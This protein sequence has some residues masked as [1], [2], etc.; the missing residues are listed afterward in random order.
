LTTLSN[1][2]TYPASIIQEQFWLINRLQPDNTAYNIPSL[3]RLKGSLNSDFIKQSVS[4]IT[5]RH[6][7][8]R[9]TF[10]SENGQLQ[11]IITDE[12]RCAFS[13]ILLTDLTSEQTEEKLQSLIRREV[14]TP[15]DLERGPLLRVTLY[16][17]S[18]DEH[19]LLIMMHHIITDLR[20]KELFSAELSFLYNALTQG[21]PSVLPP[22]EQHYKNFALWQKNWLKSKQSEAMLAYWQE[23]LRNHS[24]YLNLPTD[25]PRQPVQIL[26]GEAIPFHLPRFFTESLKKFSRRNSVNIFL[27]LLTAYLILLFRYTSQKDIV[28]GVP[29]T[30]RRHDPHKDILGCFVNILPLS[31]TIS[32]DLTFED[33]LRQVRLEMLAAHRNQEAPYELIVKSLRPKRDPSYNPLF[34]A[35]FTFEPPMELELEGVEITA[36]KIHNHGTQLDLFLTLWEKE[37]E[38][39]GFIEYNKELFDESTLTRLAGHY[40]TL[41]QSI[42]TK[43]NDL[44]SSLPFLPKSEENKI[45]VEWNNTYRELPKKTYLHTLFEEQVLINPDAVALV[46]AGSHLTYQELNIRANQ[47]AHHLLTLGVKPGTLVGV[48]M[49]RSLEMVVALL[50]ILKAGGAYVP[51]DPNFPHDRLAYMLEDTGTSI[52]LTQ[53]HLSSNITHSNITKIHLDTQWDEIGTRSILNPAVP[54][55]AED[56]AYVIYTS[57]STGKPKGVQIPHK[58]VVN[59]LL[60]MRRQPGITEKDALLAVT[61]LSFDI[62]V[63]EIFL[64]LSVGAK[65]IIASRENAT[66]GQQLLELLKK[67]A[68]TI[69]Q[70][71]P[72]TWYLLLAAGWQGSNEFKVLCG[73]EALPQDL[74]QQLVKRSKNVWNLYGPTETTIWSTCCRLQENSPEILIGR[75]I[76]NTRIYIVNQQNQLNPLGIAGELLIGGAGVSRGYINQPALTKEKFIPDHFGSTPDSLL[77]K[78]G[79]LASFMPDGNIKI[80]GRLDNQVKLRG[81]RIELG[82]IESTL[83]THPDVDQAV[84]LIREET[85][86][87]KKLVAYITLQTGRHFSEIE[88][89]RHL[90]KKLPDYMLPSIIVKMDSMPLTHNGKIDRKSLPHP[91]M[92]RPELAQEFILPQSEI[93]KI[94]SHLWSKTLKI[95]TIGID[96]NFFDLGGDSLLS[97]QLVM[98][99]EKEMQT[100]IPVVKFFQYPTIR[101]FAEYLEKKRSPQQPS[102]NKLGTRAILQR[103]VLARKQRL[104]K[105][106]N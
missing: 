34:Q 22:P 84:A 80:L 58:A 77:Y 72:A 52:L 49:N 96:D 61:T 26:S 14:E 70:A 46:F 43:P 99:L 3:F 37:E 56:L 17:I 50:G 45:L 100:E 25:R 20:S 13:S 2:H 79:D 41:L 47:L 82:E 97:V 91:E 103:K 87:D 66:N 102:Q 71:T 36:Q 19:Y 94:V 76:D 85:P 11:Q 33:V 40:E 31:F 104:T 86:G 6:E 24:G 29:L 64:P 75:P 67:S 53:E 30:N 89:R 106:T 95:D 27:T 55:A 42:L 1:V 68:T 101:S 28:I 5:R 93:E 18:D 98:L 7:I 9:T 44:I 32:H 39:H 73:G 51:L 38:V 78:T 35:G 8:F 10:A 74:A 83:K 88:L 69:M 54:L 23:H 16:R 15:F 59:F 92:K 90:K 81:F 63:L 12:P 57:G 62:S 48:F 60:S 65:T 4:E 105:R 21:K